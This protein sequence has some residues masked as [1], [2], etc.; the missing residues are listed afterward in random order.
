MV[1][2]KL[3]NRKS[4]KL[5][6][7]NLRNRP[8]CSEKIIWHY[9]CGSNLG[10]YKFRRQQ[11]IGPYVV[12]FYCP[13]AKLAVEIDG[14]SHKPNR[15]AS[16]YKSFVPHIFREHHKMVFSKDVLN[17]EA[18]EYSSFSKQISL[19]FAGHSRTIHSLQGFCFNLRFYK[20]LV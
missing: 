3:F 16:D 20:I 13:E 10:G 6:R 1:M 18:S 8:T 9:L 14:D 17:P 15:G 11:G 4:Q 19:C 7:R 5:T 2:I 12:D